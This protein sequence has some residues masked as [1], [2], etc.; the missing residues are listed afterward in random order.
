MPRAILDR[1]SASLGC[2][3]PDEENDSEGVKAQEN[4]KL[5]NN[6]WRSHRL[7]KATEKHLDC[8]A[9]QAN[10]E[11]AKDFV[12]KVAHLTMA[13]LQRVCSFPE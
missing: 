8:H 5:P 12:D 2:W 9:E 11:D 13:S 7:K 4:D 6:H 10:E 3:N 1:L